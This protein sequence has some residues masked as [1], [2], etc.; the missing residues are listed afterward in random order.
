M[1]KPSPKYT[2][3]FKQRAVEL[4]RSTDGATFASIGREI[5]VD[6]SSV[7]SWVRG[8]E[9]ATAHAGNPFQTDEELRT[10]R[11]ENARLREENEIPLKASAFFASRGCIR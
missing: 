10:L 2:A 9:G 4:Y 11:K 5:G 3:E 8:A 6:P 1:G 7:A